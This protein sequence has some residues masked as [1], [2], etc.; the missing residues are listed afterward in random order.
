MKKMAA[1]RRKTL[2]VCLECHRDT[3]TVM[4]RLEGAIGKVPAMGTR[5]SPILSQARF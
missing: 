2:V 4:R 5:W 3:E 1:R